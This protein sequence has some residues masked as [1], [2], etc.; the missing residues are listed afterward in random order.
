MSNVLYGCVLNWYQ[1]PL[2]RHIGL[3][4]MCQRTIILRTETDQLRLVHSVTIHAT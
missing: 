4:L 1:A 2:D 3:A